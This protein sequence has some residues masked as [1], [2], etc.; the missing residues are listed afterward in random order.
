M[1]QIPHFIEAGANTIT[2]HTEARPHVYPVQRIKESNVKAGVALKSAT[3]L[4]MVEARR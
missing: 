1:S 4:V 3:W 2:V